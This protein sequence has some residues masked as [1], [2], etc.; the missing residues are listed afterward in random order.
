MYTR[1]MV[2]RTAHLREL[3]TPEKRQRA[4]ENTMKHIRKRLQK[5]TNG[6]SCTFQ[7][8]ILRNVS[9]H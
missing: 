3:T 9:K 8:H 4:R 5:P 2:V 1:K 6:E 7:R